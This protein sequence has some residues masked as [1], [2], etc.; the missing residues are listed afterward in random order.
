MI[1]ID[2]IFKEKIFDDIIFSENVVI[3]CDTEEK[4][5]MLLEYADSL[6]YKWINNESYIEINEWNIYKE[7]TVYYIFEGTYG[8]INSYNICDEYKIIPFDEIYKG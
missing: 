2:D 5:N 4:A 3:H 8:L 1:E 7:E 6:G